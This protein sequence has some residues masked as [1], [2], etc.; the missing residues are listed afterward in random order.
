MYDMKDIIETCFY[1]ACLNMSLPYIGPIV[2]V[3]KSLQT[4]NDKQRIPITNHW[5][6]QYK[7]EY[8]TK[9]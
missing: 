4:R 7:R 6:P 1:F 2:P 5:K 3:P 8:L 9:Y